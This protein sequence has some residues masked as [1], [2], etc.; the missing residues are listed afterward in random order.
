MKEAGTSHWDSPNTGATNS[1]GFTALPGGLRNSSGSFG[2]LGSYGA[3]WSST[4]TSGPNAWRRRLNY[5]DD[6]ANRSLYNKAYGYSVRC[7]KD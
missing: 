4:E 6:Q 2:Y 5:D 3:W 7:L 1:S